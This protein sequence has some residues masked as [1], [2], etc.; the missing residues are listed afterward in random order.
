[1]ATS[2]K[3]AQSQKKQ[4]GLE[5]K[6]NPLPEYVQKGYK[7]SGLLKDKTAIITGGDSGIGKAVAI[8]FAE[9]GADIVISYLNED[10]DAEFTKSSQFADYFL[11][12]V[13]NDCNHDRA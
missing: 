10:K 11:I 9:E 3:P 12:W 4:P 5:Y 6:M 1:M 2:D 7:G 13:R 8:L